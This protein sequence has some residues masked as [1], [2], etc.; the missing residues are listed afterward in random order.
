MAILNFFRMKTFILATPRP[1][2]PASPTFHK[3]DQKYRFHRWWIT[4][5]W[6]EK[7]LLNNSTTN[8][9]DLSQ[10]LKSRH[11]T[12]SWRIFFIA[13]KMYEAEKLH[14]FSLYH[15]SFSNGIKNYGKK[16][17]ML[18]AVK[19]PFQ[20]KLVDSSPGGENRNFLYIYYSLFFLWV[21]GY[22]FSLLLYFS[23]SF[24]GNSNRRKKK[25]LN[26]IDQKSKES[27]IFLSFISKIDRMH[28]RI[29]GRILF[30]MAMPLCYFLFLV[31]L[32]CLFA[33]YVH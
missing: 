6:H 2:I 8:F 13:R 19:I 17:M 24:Y 25:D 14:I 32:F 4:A 7:W 16:K 31:L 5:P 9:T 29:K 3:K 11:F 15:R 21:R 28:K 23:K 20:W 18:K 33:F 1:P 27:I 26:K 30:T 22:F 10:P 12:L